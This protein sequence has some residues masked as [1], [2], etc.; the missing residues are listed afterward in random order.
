MN[1]TI[2]P[3]YFRLILDGFFP[4]L[5][6][7][8]LFFLF[9]FGGFFFLDFLKTNLSDLLINEYILSLLSYLFYF[10]I[11]VFF[12]ILFFSF[13][14]FVGNILNTKYY[15]NDNFLIRETKFLNEIREAVPIKQVT[16]TNYKISW[17]LDS[18][19]ST[20]SIS[21]YTSGTGFSDIEFRGIDHVKNIYDD[22]KSSVDKFREDII[23]SRDSKL[24]KSVKP[25]V[26]VA[27][28]LNFFSVIFSFI[29]IVLFVS[30]DFFLFIIGGLDIFWRF[31][32]ILLIFIS[33]FFYLIILVI[34]YEKKKYDFYTDRLEYID[35]F[36]T[37]YRVSVPLERITN[38]DLDR[39]IFDRIF[40]VSK[41]KVETAGSSTSEIN[42]KYVKNGE[43]IV[44]ELKEVLKE[45]GRN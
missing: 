3:N 35:G 27:T 25:S 20:G 42:I 21:L 12:L 45:N 34:S 7:S 39:S 15:I 37:K 36:L 33:L 2:V 43:D 9:I 6:A 19:F 13:V 8:F 17:F 31:L 11:F 14:N 28:L 41:I 23:S 30:L 44:L 16:N 24:L 18:I 5:I 4:F 29:F 1:Q 22:I 26:F 38:V 32:I 10:L 40:S